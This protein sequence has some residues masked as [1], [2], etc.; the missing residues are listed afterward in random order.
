MYKRQLYLVRDQLSN[1]YVCSSDNYFTQNPF[2]TYVYSAYY[3]GVFF[4]GESPEYCFIT[5]G[6]D[7][8]IV[9]YEYPSHD[10]L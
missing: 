6:K 7:N 9:G 5:K 1:T 4:E 3:S 8:L 2:E 10:S